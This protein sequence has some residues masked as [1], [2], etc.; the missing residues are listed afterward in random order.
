MDC[1]SG[2]D[3]GNGGQSGSTALGQ[4][5][6]TY[7]K[8][9]GYPEAKEL[10]GLRSTLSGPSRPPGLAVQ[11]P[12]PLGRP[13]PSLPLRPVRAGKPLGPCQNSKHCQTARLANRAAARSD[14]WVALAKAGCPSLGK[15]V[16]KVV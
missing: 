9:T 3:S 10:S 2:S 13:L 12:Q 8:R 4:W 1:D 16:G 15:A 7:T 5:T 6:R 14:S 11:L